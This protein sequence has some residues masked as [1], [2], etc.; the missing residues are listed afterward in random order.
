MDRKDAHSPTFKHPGIVFQKDADSVFGAY[1]LIGGTT[2]AF[3]RNDAV[4]AVDYL[5][6]DEAGQVSVANLVGMARSARNIILL[7]DQMQLEQP[8]RGSHPGDSG[9]S[10]LQYYLKGHSAIPAD[11]GIFLGITHRLPPHLCQ[12]ISSSIY[13]GRLSNLPA[14]AEHSLSNPKPRLI[15]KATGLLFAGV[16]H[17]GCVQSSEEE[18]DLIKDLI[19]ELKDC[20]ITFDGKSMPLIPEKHI[21]VVAPYN[22]QVRLLKRRL[23]GVEIGTVDKF[24]GK[25]KP[26]VIISMA[27]SDAAESARGM[28]FLFSKNR[29]NVAISR[30]QIMAIVVANP[31]LVYADCN[32]LKGMSLVNLFGRI[33]QC[34]AVDHVMESAM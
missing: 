34:G 11:M 6:V 27:D 19:A 26:V 28:E 15:T 23:P 21:L 32:S 18:A 4:G 33:V 8:V 30:A 13:E 20:S 7:G 29:L 10:T 9:L 25:Q 24:Q 12:F 16:P 5:F 3:S 31:L 22:K 2:Y 14:T 1:G 17:V